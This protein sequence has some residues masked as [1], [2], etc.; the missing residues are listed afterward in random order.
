MWQD[1]AENEHKISIIVFLISQ[2]IGL[3]M[4]L[5]KSKGQG[6]FTIYLPWY[7]YALI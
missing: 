6:H 2:H 4:T 3:C 5:N 1:N 7:W